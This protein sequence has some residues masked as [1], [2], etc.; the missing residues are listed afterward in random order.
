MTPQSLTDEQRRARRAHATLTAA[1][2]IVGTSDIAERWGITPNRARAL[3]KRDGFPEPAGKIGQ[4]DY[5]YA[6]DVDRWR[7]TQPGVGG[8][9]REPQP[10]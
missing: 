1:G 7:A 2:G 10:S 8:S 5:W 3:V 9:R 4:S 6:A